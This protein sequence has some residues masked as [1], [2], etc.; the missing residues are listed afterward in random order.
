MKKRFAINK[1]T[2]G[3]ELVVM[4]Q[5]GERLNTQRA[6]WL[7]DA[8]YNIL[9]RFECEMGRDGERAVLHYDVREL[10]SLKTYLKR[11]VLDDAVYIKLLMSVQEVMDTCSSNR[12]P[13]ELIQF[14]AQHVFVDNQAQ[15]RF[16]VIPLD[17][18]PFEVENSPLTM[19]K[20]L[21]NTRRLSFTS[22][23]A[24]TLSMQLEA[25]VLNQNNVFSANAFRAFLRDNCGVGQPTRNVRGNTFVPPDTG[26]WDK[27]R[28]S[29]RV[30]NPVDGAGGGSNRNRGVTAYW[31]ERLS[32]GESY[33]LRE[34]QQL[35][36]GRGSQNDVQL[37]GNPKLSRTHVLLRCVG[38]SVSLTDLGSANGTWV[39]GTRLNP[40]LDVTIPLGQRFSLANEELVVKRG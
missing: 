5:R 29:N 12:I 24:E 36:I 39:R 20:A 18:M 9:L 34:S 7:G 14:D 4:S 15:P 25:F 10:V 37:T 22:P 31:L 13:T 28:K 33:S 17:D 38:N 35:R 23:Y 11:E 40:N 32:N 3:R 8:Q 21:G 26:T 19:L 27:E 6:K 30:W 1:R 2:M 16:V